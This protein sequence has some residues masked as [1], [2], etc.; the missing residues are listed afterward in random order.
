MLPP[1][2]PEYTLYW[3][4]TIAT[5][6]TLAFGGASSLTLL[7]TCCIVFPK[8]MFP[9]VN[10]MF[11]YSSFLMS[12]SQEFMLSVIIDPNPLKVYPLIV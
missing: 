5:A 4:T 7:K 1:I 11:E 9:P 3:G 6:F 2:H 10:K 12:M 8:S